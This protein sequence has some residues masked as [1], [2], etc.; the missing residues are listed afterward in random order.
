[1][2]RQVYTFIV[3]MFF[4]ITPLSVFALADMGP[5]PDLVIRVIN[6]P[7]ERYYLDL[8]IPR[9]GTISNLE[10]DWYETEHDMEMVARLYDWGE[11]G[12]YPAFAMGGNGMLFGSLTG[13]QE[14]GEMVHRFT[15]FGLPWTFR[16]VTATAHGA[17]ATAESYTRG[18]F[19][20]VITYDY[21]EN[22]FTAPPVW[23]LYLTQFL[24]TALPTLLIESILLLLF[25]FKWRENA[26]VFLLT[27]IA[28]Q[29]FLTVTM[30]RIFIVQGGYAA[31]YFMLLPIELAIFLAE[32]FVYVRHME[33]GSMGRRIG[34]TI[35]ANAA[36]MLIGILTTT[37]L[38]EFIWN[39]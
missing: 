32:G 2:K 38:Y 8:L 22:T 34:Y 4:L 28:T 11:K 24:S 16:I 26:K 35:C 10:Y 3:C 33:G 6:A 17:Q 39:M 19:H 15:Y 23:L 36:S 13:R 18:A 25:R 12:W 5:K 7:D 31:Y 14:R 27:N 20:S 1:M 37:R 30:G 9:S 21:A 29:F